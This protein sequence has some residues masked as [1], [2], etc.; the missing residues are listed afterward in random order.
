MRTLVSLLA[1]LITVFGFYPKAGYITEIQNRT[2]TIEDAAGNL[3]EIERDPEDYEVGDGVSMIMY[4]NHT[5]CI[6]DD[7][8]VA[9]RYNG[10][11]K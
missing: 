10:Y 7:A 4:D 8:I 5:D 1:A 9:M 2:I 6:Y 3:W 11:S